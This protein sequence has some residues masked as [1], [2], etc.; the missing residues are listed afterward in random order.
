MPR[1]VNP[2]IRERLL[3]TGTKVVHQQGFNG[4]GVQD[5]TTAA[6]VPKGSFYNYFG[7]KED[8]AT[9]ILEGYWSSVETRHGPL[10]YDARVKP[11]VRIAKFFHAL[12]EDH[13]IHD[14]K[15]GCL[16]GNLSLEMSR[17]SDVNRLKLSEILKRWESA[18]ARCLKE[19]QERQEF[20]A[21]RSAVEIAASLIEC[22]EGAVMRSKVEQN[23]RACKRFETTVLPRLLS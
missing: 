4:C 19:A 12:Y 15:L 23:G 9:E 22:W 14:F 16:I 18:L 20:P 11:L 7:S 3:S 17:E 2:L 1:P 21:K 13:A 10:L 6:A 8:F 5:I